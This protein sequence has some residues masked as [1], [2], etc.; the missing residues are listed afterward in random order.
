[1]QSK[2]DINRLGDALRAGD[3][4]K[5]ILIDLDSYR[6]SFATAAAKVIQDIQELTQFEQV[7]V[8]RPSKSTPSIVA[9]LQR[10][11]TLKLSQVQDIAGLRIIVSN[12]HSQNVLLDKTKIIYPDAKVIDRRVTPSCGYRA[13]HLVV[14]I[15][16]RNIEIQIR[17]SLQQMWAHLS[18]RLA[19]TYGHE[20]KYGGGKV[21]IVQALHNFSLRIEQHEIAKPLEYP[22]AQENAS[23][24][25]IPQF[26]ADAWALLDDMAN[27][28]QAHLPSETRPLD[29]KHDFSY[30]L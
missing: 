7:W 22:Y 23:S 3:A 29:S 15:G 30:P 24:E 28:A 4:T 17:T 27:F 26:N 20:L 18:E 10:Q 25:F 21:A 2:A 19:D 8:Q 6:R 16:G 14:E 13:V 9:K 12:R 5:E 11:P 1:M